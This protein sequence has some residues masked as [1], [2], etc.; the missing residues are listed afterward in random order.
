MTDTFHS[1]LWGDDLDAASD[2]FRDGCVGWSPAADG[3]LE[4]L[5]IDTVGWKVV[6]ADVVHVESSYFD[7]LPAGSA[8]LDCVLVLRDVPF[9]WSA[10]EVGSPTREVVAVR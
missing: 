9:D 3:T 2:F 10:P 7:G 4:A 8:E 5:R 6:P 1:R